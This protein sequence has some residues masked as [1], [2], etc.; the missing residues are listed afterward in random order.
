MRNIQDFT[1]GE[2]DKCNCVAGLETF[3]TGPERRA[4]PLQ[5][6]ALQ[7]FPLMASMLVQI[8]IKYGERPKG[9]RS[10]GKDVADDIVCTT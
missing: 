5:L 4:Q 3:F 9:T 7:T 8:K 1:E 2:C 6:S 10:S